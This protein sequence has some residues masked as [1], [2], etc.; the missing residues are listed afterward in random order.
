ME[1]EITERK[2]V[3]EKKDGHIRIVEIHYR[4]STGRTGIWESAE[5]TTGND[6]V[7]V[8]PVTNDGKLVLVKQMRWTV[9]YEV[10]E[11]P[12]G[13]CDK[14]GKSA[15][16]IAFEELLEETGYEATDFE[17]IIEGPISPGLGPERRTVFLATGLKAGVKKEDE[18]EV[19]EIFLEEAEE[20]LDEQMRKG[21]FVGVG[22]LAFLNYA[23]HKFPAV[24]GR[25][26][27]TRGKSEEYS[28]MP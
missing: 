6:T 14:P 24:F 21:K 26:I 23:W 16:Q 4:T 5:R 10:I 9:G 1:G 8:I 17:K 27:A 13:L 18:I 11:F 7:Y 19:I 2:V 12:A 15:K 20:W 28:R 3:Y 22:V 25:R